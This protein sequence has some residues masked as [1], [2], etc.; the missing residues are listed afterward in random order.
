VV[1]VV[2]LLCSM[3]RSTKLEQRG[4]LVGHTTLASRWRHARDTRPC[5]CSH[6][7]ATYSTSPVAHSTSHPLLLL[8][9]QSAAATVARMLECRATPLLLLRC[10]LL[11]LKP[12]QRQRQRQRQPACCC[13][14]VGPGVWGASSLQ[15]GG[16]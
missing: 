8:L 11:L 5:R 1:V 10:R 16:L 6:S 4:E 14:C 15:R 2:R 7:F 9:L 13:L 3:C 12:G